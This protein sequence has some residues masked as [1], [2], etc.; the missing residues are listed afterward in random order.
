MD[1]QDDLAQDRE[2]VHAVRVDGDARLRA[3]RH[4]QAADVLLV[5]EHHRD[6]AGRVFRR[7][8]EELPAGVQLAFSSS[9]A[10]SR[11]SGFCPSTWALK[12]ARTLRSAA[13]AWA[14]ACRTASRLALPL[15]SFSAAIRSSVWAWLNSCWSDWKLASVRSYSCW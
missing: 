13:S 12:S 11:T 2:R 7:G 14:S 15:R 5:V 3:D 10:V 8:H 6:V 1:A 9:A 4:V